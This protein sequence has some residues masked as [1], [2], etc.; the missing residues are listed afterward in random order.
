M[1]TH[2]DALLALVSLEEAVTGFVANPTETELSEVN[3]TSSD[4]WIQLW[5]CIQEYG[6]KRDTCA[7]AI[8][9]LDTALQSFD[10][11]Q[12]SATPSCVSDIRRRREMLCCLQSENLDELRKILLVAVEEKKQK[13]MAYASSPV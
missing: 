3:R 11:M 10:Q 4:T 13:L 8:V 2:E 7:E 9:Q 6:I 12:V 1:Y 5:I